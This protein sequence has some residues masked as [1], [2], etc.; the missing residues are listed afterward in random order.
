[1]PE[2]GTK[3]TFDGSPRVAALIGDVA[4]GVFL[5]QRVSSRQC[6]EPLAGAR[7]CR[8]PLSCVVV[9]S[10]ASD[11]LASTPTHGA[12]RFAH[13]GAKSRYP[14][15]LDECV[16]VL[17]VGEEFGFEDT[18]R[19]RVVR[20]ADRFDGWIEKMTVQIHLCRVQ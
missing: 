14:M 6:P 9:W 2:P 16:G 12:V 19:R 13:E 3:G 20:S 5:F 18:E 7:E 17:R 4:N 15:Q 8:T 11:Q 10:Y 1:M